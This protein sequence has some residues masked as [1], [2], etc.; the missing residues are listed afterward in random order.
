[1][2]FEKELKNGAYFIH[3]KIFLVFNTVKLASE[4]FHSQILMS[5]I[6]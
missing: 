5:I 2:C 4:N 3:N 1:M 6:I